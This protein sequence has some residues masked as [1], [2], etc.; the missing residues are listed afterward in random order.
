MLISLKINLQKRCL[1][2][3]QKPLLVGVSGGPDSLCLLDA[4]WR[5]GFS[6]V[7]A[8]LDHQLRFASE[9]EAETVRRAANERGLDFILGRQD[10]NA[11][12]EELGLSIEEA[13][14]EARYRFLFAQAVHSGAQAVAVGHTADDQVETVLM[15]LLRGAGLSGLKGM[16]Y[17]LSPNAWSLE[18]PLVRPLLGV[19]RQEVLEYIQEYNLTPVLDESNLDTRFYRNRLRRELIPYLEEYNPRLR[20]SIWRMA[21][22]LSGDHETLDMLI[23]STWPICVRQE[24]AAFVE[25]EA[26]ILRSQPTGMQRRLLRRGIDHL[27]PGLRDVDYESLARAL[28]F[29]EAPSRSGQID[30]IAGLRLSLDAGGLWLA[31]WEGGLPPGDWPQIAEGEEQR[32]PLPGVALISGG[33]QI[34]SEILENLPADPARVWA[35]ADP[36][37]AYL[38]L[39]QL[40]TTL[41]VRSR[42]P[43]DRFQPMGMGGHSIKISDFMINARLT[44]RARQ[45]WPLVLS[46]DEI[47]WLPGF[48]LA[49]PYR[50]QETTRRWVRL[51]LVNINP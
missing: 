44:R 49:H 32:L 11:Q 3:P 43:G 6:L 12:A 41:H 9:L 45:D 13:A 10:V 17:R 22:V 40:Q 23:D 51:E 4:L 7:V 21:D 2:Q 5:M 34:R 26:A 48:R 24:G 46:G 31:T 19:W 37:Q 30:L 33:W 1:L 15:H 35:N 27:R 8:H 29:L 47:V 50:I 36:Y 28:K 14:R 20:Q 42:R 18:I 38:D 39:D 25:F 16:A